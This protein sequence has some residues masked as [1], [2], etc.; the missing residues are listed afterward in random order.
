MCSQIFSKIDASISSAGKKKED[1]ARCASTKYYFRKIRLR[2]E[3]RL[4]EMT[5]EQAMAGSGN[6]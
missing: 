4:G 3:R 1:P 5:A 6:N 2:A